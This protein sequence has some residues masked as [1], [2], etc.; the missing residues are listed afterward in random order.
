[1][2]TNAKVVVKADSTIAFRNNSTGKPIG[3]KAG[4][5]FRVY[6][7]Y[8]LPAARTTAYCGGALREVMT[9][10]ENEPDPFSTGSFQQYGDSQS[11]HVHVTI[12][13][14]NGM[15]QGKCAVRGTGQRQQFPDFLKME[16][17]LVQQIEAVVD[18]QVNESHLR[19]TFH[20]L[21][22][23]GDARSWGIQEAETGTYHAWNA[24]ATRVVAAAQLRIRY[25]RKKGK[26]PRM[27]IFRG[28]ELY[29]RAHRPSEIGHHDD[30]LHLLSGDPEKGPQDDSFQ[31]D[32]ARFIAT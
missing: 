11:H 23:L 17:A 1:M 13:N 7:E 10:Y 12:W 2:I 14:G 9:L 30:P 27:M 18:Q 21:I 4:K 19:G 6:L 28:T 24:L 15:E 32:F 8:Y 26:R 3:Q 22:A 31:H 20:V 25:W 29:K 16:L 5:G